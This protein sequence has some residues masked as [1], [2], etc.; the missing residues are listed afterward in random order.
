MRSLLV[1]LAVLG[2]FAVSMSA[3][4]G[5]TGN[6]LPFAGGPNNAGGTPGTIQSGG[7]NQTLLRFI[8]GSPDSGTGASGNVDVCVDN[9]PLNIT[10]PSVNYGQASGLYAIP[11]GITHTISVFPG[12]GT[13]T[14]SNGGSGAEC[15][16]APGPYFFNAAIAV[17]TLTTAATNNRITVVLG[18][19]AA[20]GTK[21]LY[22]YQEPSY[23]VAPAGSEVISHNAAPGF[24]KGKPGVGFG[25][26]TTTVAPCAVA[27]AL[28]GAQ[29]VAAPRIATVAASG[30]PNAF[31]QS[32]LN[33][34]PAG[35]Y[36]G[37]GVPAGIPVPI[38][39]IPAPSSVA[40]QPYVLNLYAI[41]GAAGGLNLIGFVEQ[42]LG[43][44]F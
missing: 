34:I 41:D 7:N 13:P 44:G 26:C 42:T 32:P 4:S 18:G 27:A 14:L 15:P 29:S 12:L 1:R 2:A 9:L 39:S 16:T 17:T 37:I 8:Q 33:A 22:V 21:G 19:T 3:C 23:A 24:S 40:G 5:G 6:S 20:S 25:I 35:F 38:T 10:G 36:D 43:F 11:G 31:V 28:T 30:T